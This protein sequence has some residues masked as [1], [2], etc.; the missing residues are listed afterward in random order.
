VTLE[1]LEPLLGASTI[2]LVNSRSRVVVAGD[3]DADTLATPA[4]LRTL[5]PMH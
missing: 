1:R 5:M 4:A 3:L 2:A